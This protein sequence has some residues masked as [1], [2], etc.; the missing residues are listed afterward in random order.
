MTTNYNTEI[1][2]LL[3]KYGFYNSKLPNEFR[4]GKRYKAIVTNDDR[5]TIVKYSPKFCRFL[6]SKTYNDK[7][8]LLKELET[9]HY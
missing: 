5:I 2:E 6:D 4:K 3:N 1:V 8:E 7:N 9:N